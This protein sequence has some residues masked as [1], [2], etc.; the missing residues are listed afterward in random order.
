MGFKF[1]PLTSELDLVNAAY[2]PTTDTIHV[3]K[4]GDTMTGALINTL[5]AG[6]SLVWDTNTLIV[7]ATNHR[8]GVG[9]VS[10]TQKLGVQVTSGGGIGAAT[11]DGIIIHDTSVGSAWDLANPFAAL[12][13]SSA[14]TSGIG[15]GGRARIGTVMRNAAG[16]AFR[17]SFFTAQT[18]AGNYIERMSIFDGGKIAMG[19]VGT[20]NPARALDVIASDGSTNVAAAGAGLTFVNKD[21]TVNNFSE[22]VL[23][24][25]DSAAAQIDA[26]KIAGKCTDHTAGSVAADLYFTLN[27]SGTLTT[28]MIIK[29]TGEIGIGTTSPGAKLH[30]NNADSATIVT[31]IKGAASQSAD[32]TQW[33]S[34][35]ATI[36]AAIQADG[37]LVFGPS[38][39]QDTN[40][41]RN[42]ANQ[43]K[44]DDAL[45]IGASTTTLASLNIPAGTAPTSPVE[46][47]MWGDS[48]QKAMIAYSDG[49]KQVRP[50]VIFTQTADATVTNTVAETS[51][52]G[53]GVGGLTLPA[54]FFVAGKTIRL[55]IGGIYSTPALATPSIVVKVKLGST[56]IAT[57][58][59]SG[60]LSGATNLEFDGEVAITCRTT[61][62]SGTV[63]VHGDI[64]YATG[65]GGTIS[66]D[67]L[68]NAGATTTVDTT[69]SKLLDVT[70]T[71][72]SATSTRIVKSTLTL[73]EVL[74]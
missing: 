39:S 72:D 47:D 34:S 22:F 20:A 62:A 36:L 6:N 63:M 70:V 17:F 14:D 5:A 37:K 42:A 29:S 64:E 33:Q 50:G 44:T 1:N 58:T 27:N 11:T 9:V 66:V 23:A 8:V 67:P 32:L 57:V 55:R 74:N 46:G 25:Y 40:L 2:D 52:V 51:I 49:I 7:D 43:L 59:T 45:V 56:V 65:V 73:V 19:A 69:A 21:T 15:A 10:P 60:L 12:T 38:G 48:T 26:V 54:N 31:L 16:S 71:W 24:T 35:S 68:N 4:A 28:R 3:L 30:I 13:F 18:T 41:Y 61:G 53:S